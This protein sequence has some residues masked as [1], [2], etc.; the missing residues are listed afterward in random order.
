MRDHAFN[1][2]LLAKQWWRLVHNEDSF[3]FKVLKAWYFP[4]HAPSAVE[5]TSKSSFLWCSLLKGRDIVNKGATWKVGDGKSINVWGD[6]WISQ[7]PNGCPSLPSL[8]QPT[9]MKV[10]R[11]IDAEMRV[12]HDDMVHE[13]F[14]SNEASMIMPIPLSKWTETNKLI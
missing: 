13:M 2:A 11:Q 5:P 9:P 3:S 4:S 7:F 8:Q 12:W 1:L 14:Q 10:S 6:K